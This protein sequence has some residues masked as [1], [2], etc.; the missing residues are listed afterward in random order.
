M[1][2]KAIIIEDDSRDV[3]TLK[4]LIDNYFN[5]IDIVGSAFIIDDGFKLIRSLNPDIVF[6]DIHMP[7]GEG[8]D[9][10]ERFPRRN[11]EVVVISGSEGYI[12]DMKKYMVFD[13]LMKPLN[14]DQFKASIKKL[15]QHRIENP[16]LTYKIY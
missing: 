1:K 13:Y 4:A 8:Y 5:E 2:L 3:E 11:F 14:N 15:V 6:L 10:L 9:L 16:G 12:M 7:R